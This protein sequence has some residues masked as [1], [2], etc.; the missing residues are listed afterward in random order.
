MICETD[1]WIGTE[2]SEQLRNLDY[3]IC[4]FREPPGCSLISR[5]Q[6]YQLT[7][8]LHGVHSTRSTLSTSVSSSWS[9]YYIQL[10]RDRY[11]RSRR[12]YWLRST[13][14]RTEEGC[15][16]NNKCVEVST[17]RWL[18]WRGGRH[19][20]WLLVMLYELALRSSSHKQITSDKSQ[21]E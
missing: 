9:R 15:L 6:C 21:I 11:L 1:S 5:G 16:Y 4:L 12:G 14:F 7:S 3:I 2:I 17:E 13:F 8:D 18:G 10:N 19:I 20:R